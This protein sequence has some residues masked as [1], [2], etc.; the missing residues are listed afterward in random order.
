M[1]KHRT[2]IVGMVGM[3]VVLFVTV[4]VGSLRAEDPAQ[5]CREN[6]RRGLENMAAVA[7]RHY[8]LP[9]EL[10]GGNGSF[11]GQAGGYGLYHLNLLAL[12]P[13][14]P[15][16][17][18]ALGT[19]TANALSLHAFGFETGRDGAPIQVVVTVFPD[20]LSWTFLN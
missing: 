12:R 4:T 5:I 20:S 13:S 6:L 3:S 14:N 17:W 19:I 16:G 1:T 9:V 18:F 2:N 11:N 8:F 7:Q 15:N 10:G